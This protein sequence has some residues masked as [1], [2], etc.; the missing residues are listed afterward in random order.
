LAVFVY[1]VFLLCCF[2]DQGGRADIGWRGFYEKLVPSSRSFSML[3]PWA[4]GMNWL[5]SMCW[6]PF[7]REGWHC[8]CT[9]HGHLFEGS[10]S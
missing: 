6:M 8:G 5:T 9:A 1:V 3:F 2:D 10:V 7:W 4:R